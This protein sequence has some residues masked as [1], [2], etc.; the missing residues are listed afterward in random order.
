MFVLNLFVL[1]F[2]KYGKS[3]VFVMESC[4]PLRVIDT[5]TNGKIRLKGQMKYIPSW[6]KLVFLCHPM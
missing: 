4:I 1:Q 5:D 2:L 6:N 3:V